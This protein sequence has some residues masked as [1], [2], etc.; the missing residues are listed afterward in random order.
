MD[1]TAISLSMDNELPIVVFN[2]NEEGN[3]KRV[4]FG[5]TVGTLVTG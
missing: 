4:L 3:L 1:S 5:E 2:I